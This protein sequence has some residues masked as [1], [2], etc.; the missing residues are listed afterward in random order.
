MAMIV[1][2]FGDC[3]AH[4]VFGCTVLSLLIQH[5]RSLFC[6]KDILMVFEITASGETSLFLI[7]TDSE[8]S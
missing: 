1:Y 7:K 8:V 5:A 6:F 3:I 4:P 2:A